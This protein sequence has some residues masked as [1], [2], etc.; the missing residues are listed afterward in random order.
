MGLK[1]KS[2]KEKQERKRQQASSIPSFGK[3]QAERHFNKYH[4]NPQ[5]IWEKSSL[6]AEA[7]RLLLLELERRKSKRTAKYLLDDKF[8][9]QTGFIKDT[10][11][12]KAALCTRRA[13]KSFGAGLY[14]CQT[15]LENPGASL[16]Y[17][18]L[19]RDSAKRIMFK[20][21]LQ[22]IDRKY[23]LNAKFNQ[24]D[25]TMTFPNGA[26]IYL[27]GMDHS[28][29]EAEKV[30]GQKFKLCI[31]DEAASFRRDLKQ[32]IFSTLKPA[33]ADLAGTICMIGTP[34]NFTKSY[35][36]EVA[37]KGEPGWSVHKWSAFDNP[38]MKDAWQREIDELTE[39]NPRIQETPWFVQNYLGKYV[40][41]QS[42]LCYAFNRDRNT[43]PEA[44]PHQMLH[45]FGI[46]LG[47]NDATAISVLAYSHEHP[48]VVVKKVFKQ[49]IMILSEVADVLRSMMQVYNPVRMRVDN[50]SKQAVEE[51]KQRYQ[52]PLLPADKQ[53]KADF[54]EL[55][56]S[57]FINDK[58]S[59]VAGMTDE[60]ATEYENLIWDDR[61]PRRQEHP[62][63]ENHAADAT[64]YAWR[65]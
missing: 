50:A 55:M 26:V 12:M 28:D 47:Y 62:A 52:L 51:L 27:V 17:I 40:I 35:F 56:N 30:L 8:K 48:R 36:Y 59:L 60:L 64:L 57:E 34:G 1:S 29:A 5:K 46:D 23:S 13:G 45:V 44:P 22:V 37:E 54:I 42:K 4:T 39:I 24:I 49:S 6:D 3:E 21:V 58:I 61:A 33:V 38:Y 43:V 2:L 7:A 9:A 16:L 14:L 10:A 15:A 20:D 65:D 53:G 63:C 41:D 31:I 18:A 32:I 11:R 25:L 19:I